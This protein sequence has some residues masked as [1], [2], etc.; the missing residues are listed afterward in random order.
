MTYQNLKKEKLDQ[1]FSG[2]ENDES[3]MKN[4]E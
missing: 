3:S 1:Q 2:E 4:V